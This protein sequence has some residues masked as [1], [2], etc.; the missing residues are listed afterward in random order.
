[1]RGGNVPARKLRSR[2]WLALPGLAVCA[3]TVAESTPPPSDLRIEKLDVFFRS[4]GCPAPHH[5]VDYVRAADAFQV[6]YRLLPVISLLESTCGTYATTNNY[7]GWDGARSD[8]E[9]VPEGIAFVTRQLAA[10]QPYRDKALD[11]KLLAYN[12]ETS[13]A[14]KVIRLMASIEAS[15]ISV[16]PASANVEGSGAPVGSPVGSPMPAGGSVQ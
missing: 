6:D 10:G 13:Y 11:Q 2:W 4:Y 8:F 1:M 9:S 5:A 16:P 12:P 7:W 15:N 3:G 14:R